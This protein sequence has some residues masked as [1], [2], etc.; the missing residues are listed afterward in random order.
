MYFDFERFKKTYGKL[1]PCLI[2]NRENVNKDNIC[3]CKEFV[4]SGYC[5]CNLFIKEDC[6]QANTGGE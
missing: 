6:G 2:A 4:E 5:R 3:P 1:C